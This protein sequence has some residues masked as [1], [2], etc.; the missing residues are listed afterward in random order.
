MVI[1]S[2]EFHFVSVHCGAVLALL[3]AYVVNLCIADH[4][5]EGWSIVDCIYFISVTLY[6]VGYGDFTPK[7]DISRLFTIVMVLFGLSFVI[8]SVNQ[9]FR[10][11]FIFNF[12]NFAM[13]W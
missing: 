10:G 5:Y 12:M 1:I 9:I 6:T 13:L 7:D 2:W 4:Q 11:S 3:T 8:S